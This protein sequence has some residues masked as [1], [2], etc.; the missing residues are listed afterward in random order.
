[1]SD[2]PT[3]LKVLRYLRANSES[4]S[5]NDIISAVHEGQALVDR[6]LNKLVAEGIVNSRDEGYC[7]TA[8]PRAEELSQKLF[9]LYEKAASRQRLELLGRGLICQAEEYYPLRSGTFVHVLEREGFAF[10]DVTRFLDGEVE[11]GYVKKVPGIF[12]ARVS[13]SPPLFIPPYYGSW[14]T[15][16]YQFQHVGEWS[17]ASVPPHGEDDYVIGDYP[18][19]LAEP[20][21]RYM[22]AEKPGLR[23]V[24]MGEVF[25]RWYGLDDPE[26]RLR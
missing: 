18:A 17:C 26:T 10:E 8:T 13:G 25:R 15:S 9:A 24:P 2:V 11:K 14:Q 3:L 22:E 4:S 12:G 23:Q 20:A 1:M 19:E 7:Y 16:R 6:A 5:Y 21:I